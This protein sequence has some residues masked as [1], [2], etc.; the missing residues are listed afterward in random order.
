MSVAQSWRLRELSLEDA[1]AIQRFMEA[2]ADYFETC[3]GACPGPREAQNELAVLPEGARREQKRF[4]GIEDKH[5]DL[6]GV[7]DEVA[8]WPHQA[9]LMLGLVLLRPDARGCGLASAVLDAREAEWR[10]RGLDR[11]RVGVVSANE[12]SLRFFARRGFCEVQRIVRDD[13][14]RP[15]EIVVMERKLGDPGRS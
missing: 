13:A 1:P 3:F 7:L 15:Y 12:G 5:G 10:A 2:S 8:D 9:T 14:P 4:L 6:L 11:V